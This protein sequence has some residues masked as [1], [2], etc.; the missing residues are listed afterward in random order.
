MTAPFEVLRFRAAPAGDDVA[1]VEL[2]GRFGGV[3]DDRPARL[4]VEAP[5]RRLELRAAASRQDGDTWRATF[6]VPLDLADEA[7]Y[8]LAMRGMV[9]DLPEPDVTEDRVAQLAR[10]LNRMRR[11][12]EAAE[13]RAAAVAAAAEQ[14]AAEQVRAVEQRAEAA[15]AEARQRAD[16]RVSAAEGEA[17]AARSSLAQ[18]ER[19]RAEADERLADARRDTAAVRSEL[20]QEREAGRAAVQALQVAL[21]AARDE[22]ADLRRALKQARAEV[23]AARR[24]QAAAMERE[25]TARAELTRTVAVRSGEPR[26]RPEPVTERVRVLR[27]AGG[28]GDEAS[29]D[30]EPDD[31]D[32]GDEPALEDDEPPT[33]VVRTPAPRRTDPPTLHDAPVP[34]GEPVERVRVLGRERRA[35]DPGAPPTP[36]DAPPLDPP[37]RL[38]ALF[39]LATLVGIAIVVLALLFG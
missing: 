38:G 25:E 10:E 4:L 23:E 1:L 28:D 30:D 33:R 5:H 26:A 35:P 21:E 2:T 37:S 7:S 16:A 24:E 32:T 19:R 17:N 31:E 13:Q 20:E 36:V 34:A 12:V 15:L 18:A 14:A 6:A 11:A 29:V 27:P 3:P 8:A 9:L 22:T 39:V